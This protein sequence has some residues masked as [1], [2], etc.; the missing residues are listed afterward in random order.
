[1]EN[2]NEQNTRDLITLYKFTDIPS[3]IIIRDSD[4]LKLFTDKYNAQTKGLLQSCDN[5][6]CALLLFRKS[7]F[8]PRLRRK[9]KNIK[10]Q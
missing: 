7:G 6:S 4:L 2:W 9:K 10:E 1:M 8:L 3:D 5:I